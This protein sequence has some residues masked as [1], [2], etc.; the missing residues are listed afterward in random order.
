MCDRPINVC[1]RHLQQDSCQNPRAKLIMMAMC[2]NQHMAAARTAMFRGTEQARRCS[3]LPA[4]APRCAYMLLTCSAF[5]PSG[6]TWR[7]TMRICSLRGTGGAGGAAAT[8]AITVAGAAACAG[9]GAAAAAGA[10][11][12]P[13]GW[14]AVG[15]PF[16]TSWEPLT[17]SVSS[18]R[19]INSSVLRRAPAPAA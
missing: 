10:A 11:G 17:C 13:A 19:Q 1:A 9:S 8:A 16:T 12:A 6:A 4:S 7:S 2:C 15:T 5:A 18:L 14:P 3:C